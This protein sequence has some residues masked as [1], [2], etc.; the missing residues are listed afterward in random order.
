MA[1]M[2]IGRPHKPTRHQLDHARDRIESSRETR[3]AKVVLLG[4]DVV[5]LRRAMRSERIG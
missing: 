4:A 5:T 2:N 3:A 1:S